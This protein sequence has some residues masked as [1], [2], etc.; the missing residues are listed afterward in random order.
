MGPPHAR[1]H[2]ADGAVAQIELGLVVQH[3][4]VLGEGLV[5]QVA[6]AQPLGQ[7]LPDMTCDDD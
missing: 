7:S 4:L 3:D 6:G 1:L 5:Q 2:S